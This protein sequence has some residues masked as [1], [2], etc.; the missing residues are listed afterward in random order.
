MRKNVDLADAAFE[1][2][3]TH[4]GRTLVELDISDWK[5]LSNEGLMTIGW[6][7]RSL[8]AIN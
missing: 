2:L 3:L 1:G 6:T 4:S 8:G 7:C 5:T